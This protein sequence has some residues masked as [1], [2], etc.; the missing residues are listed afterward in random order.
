[1]A[2][3]C[4]HGGITYVLVRDDLDVLDVTSGLE[5][6]AQDILRDAG[7]KAA[8]I[9]GAL[10]GLGGGATRERAPTGRGHDL[11]AAHGRGDGSRNRVGVGRNVQRR[12]RH[13]SVRAPILRRVIVTGRSSVGLGRWRKLASGNTRISHGEFEGLVALEAG[14]LEAIRDGFVLAFSG[15][16][17]AGSKK[18]SRTKS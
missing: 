7:I 15:K 8:D 6:L 12:G 14:S 16:G 17:K 18:R 4:F 1:M 2:Q 11:V 5:D 9:Q 3:V 13:V 10:V